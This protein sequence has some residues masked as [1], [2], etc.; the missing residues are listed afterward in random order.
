MTQNSKMFRVS[1]GQLKEMKYLVVHQNHGNLMKLY[2]ILDYIEKN[3]E[4]IRWDDYIR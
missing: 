2:N 4:V 3:R 1:E